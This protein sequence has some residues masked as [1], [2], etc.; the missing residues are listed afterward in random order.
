METT[1]SVAKVTRTDATALWLLALAL[2]NQ[3]PGYA[4][5]EWKVG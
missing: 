1:L 5:D 4:R 2:L 3:T